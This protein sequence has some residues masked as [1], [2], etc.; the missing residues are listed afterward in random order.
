V[1]RAENRFCESRYCL[2][3]SL[4]GTAVSAAPAKAAHALCK[5]AHGDSCVPCCALPTLACALPGLVS[6]PHRVVS[7]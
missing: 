5:E 7:V 4:Q 6:Q 1:P 2:S 3:P